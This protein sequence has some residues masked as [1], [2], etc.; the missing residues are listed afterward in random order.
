MDNATSQT[1]VGISAPVIVALVGV[2]GGFIVALIKVGMTYLKTHTKNAS[3]QFLASTLESE[4]VKHVNDLAETETAELK[5]AFNSDKGLSPEK[6][7]ELLNKLIANSK[8]EAQ[9]VIKSMATPA[10]ILTALKKAI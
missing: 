10:N 6:V 7:Q 8:G 9:D 5:A 4:L 2:I 1:I 3:L